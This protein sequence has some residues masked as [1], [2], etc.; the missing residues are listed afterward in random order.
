M[1]SFKK[2][3]NIECPCGHWTTITF[4]TVYFEPTLPEPKVRMMK[5]MYKPVEETKCTKCGRVIAKPEELFDMH[6]CMHVHTN[7]LAN[8]NPVILADSARNSHPSPSDLHIFPSNKRM[9]EVTDR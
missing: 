2:T 3:L 8:C 4:S 7:I 5:R 1:N 9:I 6:A